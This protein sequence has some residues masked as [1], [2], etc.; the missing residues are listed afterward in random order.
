MIRPL[1]LLFSSK[2]AFTFYIFSLRDFSLQ[3]YAD[4]VDAEHDKTRSLIVSSYNFLSDT[5]CILSL[6]REP[7]CLLYSIKQLT[8]GSQVN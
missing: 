7:L 2:S 3:L 5:I 8:L 4:I 6:Y 1:I